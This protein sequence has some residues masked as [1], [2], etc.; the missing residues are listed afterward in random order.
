[1]FGSSIAFV[2]GALMYFNVVYT[3][4][5]AVSI[6]CACRGMGWWVAHLRTH[7]RIGAVRAVASNG[8]RPAKH[9]R[10]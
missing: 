1:M 3:L 2:Y 10:A 4:F 8:A 7:G 5:F 9:R 6:V